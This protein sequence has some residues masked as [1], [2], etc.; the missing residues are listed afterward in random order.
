MKWSA[1]PDPSSLDKI[2]R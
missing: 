2:R 1:L